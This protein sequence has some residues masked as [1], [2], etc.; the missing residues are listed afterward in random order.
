MKRIDTSYTACLKRI[1]AEY[2]VIKSRRMEGGG[3]IT[4]MGAKT[5]AYRM[6]VVES[7][8]KDY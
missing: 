7:E 2:K 8:E 5:N 4:R 3:L 1:L 6:L